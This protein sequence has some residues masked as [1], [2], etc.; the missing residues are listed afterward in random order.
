MGNAIRKLKAAGTGKGVG[1]S[2]GVLQMAMR[3]VEQREEEWIERSGWKMTFGR[4]GVTFVYNTWV[5]LASFIDSLA[6]LS[7]S[8]LF[9]AST[10]NLKF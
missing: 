3:D 5:S 6:F 1:W 7:F 4:N 9:T 2:L 10:S 8:Q